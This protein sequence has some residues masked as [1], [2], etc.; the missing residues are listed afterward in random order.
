MG[1]EIRQNKL[2]GITPVSLCDSVHL[3]AGVE[4]AYTFA[5]NDL[6]VDLGVDGD[7]SVLICV[8]MVP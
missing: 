1:V 4:Y 8:E 5:I 6:A 3:I 2:L 7:R